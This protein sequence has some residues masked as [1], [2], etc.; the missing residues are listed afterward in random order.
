MDWTALAN[1]SIL[2][3]LVESRSLADMN[4]VVNNCNLLGIQVV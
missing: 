4:L 3:M 2:G 1:E